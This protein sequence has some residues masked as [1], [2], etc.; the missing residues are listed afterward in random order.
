MFVIC[1]LLVSLP[2]FMCQTTMTAPT[3]TAVNST[4]MATTEPT[5][6]MTTEMAGNVTTTAS[7]GNSTSAGNVTTTDTTATPVGCAALKNCTSCLANP[8]CRYCSTGA[9]K[10]NLDFFR[11]QRV[12]RL[13][14]LALLSFE[15]ALTVLL[16]FVYV[17]MSLLLSGIGN[18]QMK[19]ENCS[20]L[21]TTADAPATEKNCP[22]DN[23][24]RCKK[25]SCPACVADSKC[26]WC[27]TFQAGLS[28]FSR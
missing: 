25:L 11:C 15:F 4:A 7:A 8:D 23:A 13:F 1:V 2:M 16:P 10:R 9:L 20:M 5:D 6:D 21:Q 17:G 24:L 22:Y 28:Q 3:S 27:D 26:V 18:C 19:T 12:V 14:A